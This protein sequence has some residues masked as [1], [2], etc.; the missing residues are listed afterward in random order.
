MRFHLVYPALID[1]AE[2]V[3]GPDELAVSSDGATPIP[4]PVMARALRRQL[5]HGEFELSVPDTVRTFVAGRARDAA[6]AIEF[7]A[8][9]YRDGGLP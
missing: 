5:E 3:D 9:L 1:L 6:S 8:G 4:A 7:M 2:G